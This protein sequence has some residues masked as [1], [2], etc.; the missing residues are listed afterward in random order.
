MNPIKPTI[1][2]ETIP[3][4]LII[5]SV[6]LSFYFFANF[7]ERVPIHWNAAGEVDNYGSKATGAFLF[8]G[9]IL[10]MYLMFLVIPYADPKKERYQQFRKIYHIFKTLLIAMMF[11]LYI[12]S[13]LASLGYD[14]QI[15]LWVPAMIGGLFILLGNYMAKIKPNWFM[16]IRTPWTLSSEEVWNKTHRVGGKVFMLGGVLIALTSFVSVDF[17]MIILFIAI[18]IMV[19]GT[20][21]YSY[22]AYRQEE[23][24]KQSP[25]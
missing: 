7:P 14:I 16:G 20:V 8:P 5:I 15:S 23:K 21:L 12:L 3:L 6:V 18:G 17:R 25:S 19:V 1:K 22:L 13:G 4:L 24:K 2:T 10:G 11:V 9:I